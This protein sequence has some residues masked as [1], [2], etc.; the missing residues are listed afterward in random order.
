MH[1][2]TMKA[3]CC[4]LL[5]APLLL[6]ACERSK[7]EDAVAQLVKAAQS[8]DLLT[9]RTYADPSQVTEDEAGLLAEYLPQV[10]GTPEVRIVED[11]AS[12]RLGV[13]PRGVDTTLTLNLSLQR[14]EKHWRVVGVDNQTQFAAALAYARGVKLNLTNLAAQQQLEKT[15]SL[16][17]LER[18]VV[19]T[20]PPTGGFYGGYEVNVQLP[21]TNRS[22]QAI[23]NLEGR[24]DFQIPGA[25]WADENSLPFTVAESI[26]PGET[27]VVRL[28][29]T[30]PAMQHTPRDQAIAGGGTQPW[31]Q[32]MTVVDGANSQE[33]RRYNTWAAYEES[34]D[35]K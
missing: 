31:L 17:R 30:F 34:L 33:V 8:A 23:T 15:A 24:I 12:A 18:S 3:L 10:A 28:K 4:V 7:P 1:S 14:G 9:F 32:A 25:P 11:V 21:V 19:Y 2:S 6:S 29:H 35:G 16:G 22:D 5:G 13:R 26:K 27:R 20:S